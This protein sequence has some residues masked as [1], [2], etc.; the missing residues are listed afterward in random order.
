LL[1][2]FAGVVPRDELVDTAGCK[3]ERE[4]DSEV[5]AGEQQKD[6]HGLEGF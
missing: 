4:N 3:G 6:L 5:E 1:D 2:E